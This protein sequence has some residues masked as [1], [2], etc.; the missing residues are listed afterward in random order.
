[1]GN[2]TYDTNELIYETNRLTAIENRLVVTE[3]EGGEGGKE[4]EFGMRSC[5][6][7]SI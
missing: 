5:Q 4:W 7:T 6:L 1:M 3:W 2:L